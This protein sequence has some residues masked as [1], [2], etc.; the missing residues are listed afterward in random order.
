MVRQFRQSHTKCCHCIFRFR[1]KVLTRFKGFLFF[2]YASY[3][4]TSIW[5]ITPTQLLMSSAVGRRPGSCTQQLSITV[6]MSSFSCGASLSWGRAGRRRCRTSIMTCESVRR[7]AN[8]DLP[9]YICEGKDRGSACQRQTHTQHGEEAEEAP[10]AWSFQN[11][12]CL[13][14]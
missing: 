3:P 1:S 4:N 6:H 7:C 14:L 13:I 9:V 5:Y 2:T 11:C 10:R 8:G 12:R